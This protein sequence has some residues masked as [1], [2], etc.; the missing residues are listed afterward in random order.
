MTVK[1]HGAHPTDIHVGRQLRT[2]RTLL[3][4]SQSTLADKVGLTFQ[5]IQKYE[6]G[7]NRIGASR[8]HD[9]S[10]ILDI[11]VG[12][13]FEGL[14]NPAAATDHLH[15]RETLELVRHY[16][17]IESIDVRK[18]VYGL[19]KTIAKAQPKEEDEPVPMAAE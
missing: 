14:D 1:E 7:A 6:R 10:Q 18:Q 4:L 12:Y 3:G 8:L 19:V 13:F 5:Q 15:S 9:F 16:H 11:P 2:R 17:G